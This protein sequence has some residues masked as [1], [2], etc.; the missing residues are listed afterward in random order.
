M[1]DLQS[2]KMVY[3]PLCCVRKE[4]RLHPCILVGPVIYGDPVA[5]YNR[6]V[7]RVPR[8]S[9]SVEV[10]SYAGVKA[11]GGKITNV[12]RLGRITVPLEEH[13]STVEGWVEDSMKEAGCL[14]LSEDV[15]SGVQARMGR[16]STP[17]A[18]QTMQLEVF[19]GVIV[20]RK[21]EVFVYRK[22]TSFP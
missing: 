2:T 8:N 21:E 19:G 12:R 10:G 11:G 3:I 4:K 7:I 9:G 15:I 1:A 6:R 18:G 22:P 17:L 20:N 14:W 16:A 5:H 13:L